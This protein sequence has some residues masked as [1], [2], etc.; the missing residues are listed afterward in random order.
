ML[1]FSESKSVGSN[2]QHLTEEKGSGAEVLNT[3]Y[4]KDCDL[5][6]ASTLFHKKKN[7]VILSS[8]RSS[9]LKGGVKI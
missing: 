5:T 9:L 3:G 2:E 1:L 8:F 6:I 7:I 4:I